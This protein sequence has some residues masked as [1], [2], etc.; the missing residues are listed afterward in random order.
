MCFPFQGTPPSIEYLNRIFNLGKQDI[1][2]YF[3]IFCYIIN[4]DL[5][6]KRHRLKLI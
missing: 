3:V 1:L 5:Q 4:D 6:F 2:L